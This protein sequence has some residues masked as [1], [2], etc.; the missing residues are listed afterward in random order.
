MKVTNLSQ[1]L[2]VL[3]EILGADWLDFAILIAS[4][5]RNN[6]FCFRLAQKKILS[7]RKSIK[8]ISNP[9][10]LGVNDMIWRLGRANSVP[11]S[12]FEKFRNLGPEKV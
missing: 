7:R 9:D 4:I 5:L 6:K 12:R 10:S 1:N 3:I 8:T 2:I 11:Q